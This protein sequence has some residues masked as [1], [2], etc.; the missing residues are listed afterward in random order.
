ML[1]SLC[2]CASNRQANLLPTG[3]PESDK[4]QEE[5]DVSLP[6]TDGAPGA[7][8]G[9]TLAEPEWDVD[10]KLSDMQADP[11]NPLYSVK[12]FEDLQL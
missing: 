11:N 5:S 7:L 12:T 2:R 4:K 1:V 9:S 8:N 3:A 10:V 6:Q